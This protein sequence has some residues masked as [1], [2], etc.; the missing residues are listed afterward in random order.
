MTRTVFSLFPLVLSGECGDSSANGTMT[1]SFHILSISL[2]NSHPTGAKI[3]SR[4]KEWVKGWAILGNK[5]F[6]FFKRPNRI[7]GPP[8]LFSG[9]RWLF[10][11]RKWPKCAV[12]NSPPTV[13]SLRMR[14]AIF[15]STYIPSWSG[16][17]YPQTYLFTQSRRYIVR[18]TDMV[19]K[20]TYSEHFIFRHLQCILCY[21]NRTWVTTNAASVLDIFHCIR[22][23]S[24]QH[25]GDWLSS[26]LRR[27]DVITYRY[28]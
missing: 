27:L 16:Q 18:A 15:L 9:Y 17:R 26:I 2:F 24:S 10:P 4:F 21:M 11:F 28:L 12:N 20:Q 7:W 22:R 13:P 8:N 23:I 19:I 25:F 14:G 3:G 6:P 1:I 5:N